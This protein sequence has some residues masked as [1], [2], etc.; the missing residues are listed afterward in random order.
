MRAVFEH[1][2]AGLQ[3]RRE[4]Q[5]WSPERKRSWILQTLRLTVRRAANTTV[6]YR[7]LF[8]GIGFDPEHHF[9]FEDFA[10]LPI[11]ERR[12][13]EGAGRNLLS[14]SVAA[15]DRQ[16]DSTGGSTGTPT[17][18]WLGPEERGWSESGLQHS[19]ERIG[20]PN[21]S[22]KAFFWGHHLDPHESDSLADRLRGFVK[23]ERYFDCFR[24][25][26]DVFR[27][28][29]EAFES[30]GPD[31][32]VAYASSLGQFAEYLLENQITPRNYPRICFVTGAEK[33][34]SDH[35]SA[36]ERVFGKPVH[37]RYGGRDFGG[38]G[39][40]LDPFADSSF[41][42]DWPWAL[43][44][45]ETQDDLSPILVTKF[46]ADAMPMIR[47]R[48][49]DVGRFSAECVP[50]NPSFGITEVVGRDVDKIV[51]RDGG[52]IDGLEIPHMMKGFPI[53]EF[54]LIQAEDYSV[55]LQIVPK[56]GFAEQ[57]RSEILRLIDAN[58]QGLP[59]RIS[60]VESIERTTA[61]K[62]RPVVSKVKGERS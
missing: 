59:A 62:W 39:I 9:G 52:T 16:R 58:L 42:I 15:E 44:E 55:E 19:F 21:T 2:R 50:G 12:D 45:P 28:Y 1:Y 61:N 17:E 51:R 43:V 8:K 46:H 18:I 30:Y 37:E 5:G 24:L 35:R 25:S 26:P 14:N 23:N 48:T 3:F 54:M 32:I 7:E 29:H 4:A 49:G 34:F 38:L 6:Y 31:C 27:K 36:I 41:D 20:V 33:L 53:R 10:K 56:G 40:Q 60:L 57:H 13:I 22:R 11:F 47:Y